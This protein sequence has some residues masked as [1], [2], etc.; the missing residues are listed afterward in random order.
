MI[1]SNKPSDCSVLPQVVKIS[2]F[3][4]FILNTSSQFYSSFIFYME[5]DK[6]MSIFHQW[7]DGY[8]SETNILRVRLSHDELIV[9]W[10]LY[11]VMKNTYRSF[12]KL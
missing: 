5:T 8:S 7:E 12:S 2:T 6:F 3:H 10:E 9:K 11:D 4:I 1:A